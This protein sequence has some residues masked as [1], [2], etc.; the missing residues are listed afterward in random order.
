MFIV[1]VRVTF[2]KKND[3]SSCSEWGLLVFTHPELYW[4]NSNYVC[5]QRNLHSLTYT[6]YSWWYNYICIQE[7]NMYFGSSA[8]APAEPP[9]TSSSAHTHFHSFVYTAVN[10]QLS[11]K[12]DI[13]LRNWTSEQ[14]DLEV[15]LCI[16]CKRHK[17][18]NAVLQFP[19][20]QGGQNVAVAT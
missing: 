4:C 16:F 5:Q 10:I 12:G 15:K 11:D 13:W 3:D 7:L 17:W 6:T 8:I 14:T 20:K 1:L 19:E 2:W 9:S 18:I